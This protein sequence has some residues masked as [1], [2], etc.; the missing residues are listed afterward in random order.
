MRFGEIFRYELAHRLR[1]FSTWFYAALL[2]L[3]GFWIMHVAATGTNPVHINAPKGLAEQ[4]ALFCGLFGILVTAGLCSDAVIRDR[5]SGMDVLLFTTRLRPAEYLHGRFLAALAINGILA[6]AIPIGL[7]LATKMPY[8]PQDAFGPNQLAAYLQ[9]LLL[10][11]LPNLVL[12]GAIL[13]TIAALT[14]QTIPVYLGAIAILIG[15]LFAA[16]YWSGITNPVLSA[17]ADPLG[18][19]ALKSMTAYWTAS[20]RNVRLI[21]FP[22]MLLWNRLLW[23]AIAAT[24]IAV[25]P[26]MFRF[27]QRDAKLRGRRNQSAD[28]PHNVR[29]FGPV[30]QMRGL[31]GPRTRMRQAL[32]VMRQS[33]AEVMSARAFP[34]AFLAA[35]G[36]VLLWGWNVGSTIYDTVTWPLTHLVATVVLSERAIVIPWLVV[37]LFAGELVWKD[38]ET[39]AAQIADAAP[40]RASVVLS[41]RFLALVALI[42]LFQL[43]CM[44]GGILLQT[45]HGYYNYELGLYLRILFGWNFI[46]YVLLAAFAMT[47]HV[48][49]NH[50]YVGHVAV[51]LATIFN[52]VAMAGMHPLLIYNGGPKLLY[53]EMNGFGPFVQPF[54]WFKLYWTAWAMLLGI[55]T[56]LF[57][58]RGPELGIR[59]RLATARARF[60]GRAARFT[61]L[62]VALIVAIGGFIFYNTNVLNAYVTPQKAGKSQAEY[63]R[64]YKRYANLPQPVIAGAELRFEVHPEAPAVDMRGSYRLVNQTAVPIRSVHVETPSGRDYEVRSMTFDRA[65]KAELVDLAH[66]YRI[67]ALERALA[68]GESMRFSF[69]TA[70]RPRGFRHGGAQTDVVRNGSYFDRRR[71]PFIG[72]QP[73]FEISGEAERKRY[74][75]PPQTPMP[76]PNDAA[77]RQSQSRYRDGDRM[78]VETIVGTAPDQIA[79]VPGM[80][81]RTWTENGR[82]YFH[83]A[84]R[85]PETFGTSVFSAKYAVQEGRW[86]DVALQIF[87]HPPHRA[88]L[89][90]MMAGMQAALDYYTSAFGPFPYRELR[91]VEVPPYSINGRAFP[92]A[93]ALSEQ[94]FITRTGPAT[95]DLT[96]FGVAHEVAH[97]WWGGQVRPAFAKGR[98]FVSE[99]LANYSAMLVTEKVLGQAEA[100]RVYDFQMDRYLR[101]RGETGRDVPLL[102]VDDLP[103]VSYGKGAVALYTLRENIGAE[104]VNT[105]LRRFLEKYRGS[106][107]PYPTSAD[108]YAEL[109]AVTPPELQ[110]LLTDL[111]ATITLWDIKTQNATTRR[112]PDGT[113]EVTLEVMAQKLRS[114]GTGVETAIPMNDVVEIGVFASD[115]EEPLYVTRQR[116]RSGKQT[117]HFVVAQEPSR[118]GVDPYQKLIERERGDNVVEVEKGG[119]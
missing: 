30:P 38:R 7:A 52:S 20:E 46:E 59:Q 12:I 10:F 97:H 37:A 36:L 61:G 22:P 104:A 3:L 93:I 39:G 109:R 24:W 99:S 60:R 53:S 56:M 66:G 54:V 40:V 70:F 17:L 27:T 82:R 71:L 63:E 69:D 14:R 26:R 85:L 88:N 41:G 45:L 113:Y 32:A 105:A 96:F 92:S 68:P 33:L 18:I 6:F 25:L 75:L 79:V 42:A 103:H 4:T 83:Y 67:F 29:P 13:F 107:P 50:K 98:T 34:M 47:V 51:L 102:E 58:A 112:L 76:G 89:D 117:L 91:V 108:L 31:F 110:S 77:A 9:P 118:T 64:L 95:V 11:V 94:N 116:V 5:T 65:S 78:Q 55:I 74:N 101:G 100:R 35:I 87:H 72:Y 115:Q 16:S 62:A 90:R 81:R 23:L 19:N 119:L 44:I 114:D 73:A 8:L 84:S 106:G 2:F 28:A 57:W 15:Y 21:G 80:L 1:S 111:F 49:V 48:L 86:R 43:A